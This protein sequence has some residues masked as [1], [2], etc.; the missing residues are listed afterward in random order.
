MKPNLMLFT[1]IL[2]LYL[3][4]GQEFAKIKPQRLRFST[5]NNRPKTQYL[6]RKP[7][8]MTTEQREKARERIRQLNKI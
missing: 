1:Q 3:P 8:Q 2:F 6:Q 5:S 4:E 7:R